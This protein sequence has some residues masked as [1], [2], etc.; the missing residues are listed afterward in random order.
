[1]KKLRRKRDEVASAPM[2]PADRS[3]TACLFSG[4]SH[5]VPGRTSVS[6]LVADWTQEGSGKEGRLS[7]VPSSGWYIQVSV[8]Q[9]SKCEPHHEWMTSLIL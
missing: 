7:S 6:C 2:D 8:G 9:R 3:S 5:C 4:S 1:M